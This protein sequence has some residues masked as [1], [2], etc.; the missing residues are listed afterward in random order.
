MAVFPEKKSDSVYQVKL[1]NAHRKVAALGEVSHNSCIG[2][3]HPRTSCLFPEELPETSTARREPS[4]VGEAAKKNKIQT[5]ENIVQ[6]TVNRVNS[7]E[8]KFYVSSRV[9]FS[10]SRHFTVLRGCVVGWVKGSKKNQKCKRSSFDLL[11][12]THTVTL[13]L[14]IHETK[15]HYSQVS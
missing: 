10:A 2:S 12:Q 3:S 15:M 4:V 5:K 8:I 11:T 9:E 13:T 6:P 14:H 1:Q 7:I